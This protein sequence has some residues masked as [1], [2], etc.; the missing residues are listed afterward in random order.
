MEENKFLK[1]YLSGEIFSVANWKKKI[2]F[3]N[4]FG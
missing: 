1:I 4:L 3:I 2:N